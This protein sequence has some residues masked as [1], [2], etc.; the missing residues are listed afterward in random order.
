MNKNPIAAKFFIASIFC[1]GFFLIS[2]QRNQFL[3]P[4]SCPSTAPNEKVIQHTAYSL[5]YSH[6]HMQSKWVAYELSRFN[7][8]GSAERSRKF[9]ID[10]SI[11]PPTAQTSDYTK[12][13]YDRGHLAPAGDMKFSA[14]AML[15][16][17]YMSNVS[18]QLPGFNRGIWKKL[19]EQCRSWAPTSHPIFMVTGP[20]L[21][22][23]LN[24]H[25]GKTCS[26]SVPKR[27][28]KVLLDTAAP[29]RAIGF[30][31]E[32]V[33]STLPLRNFALSIDEVEKITG[34]DFFPRLN[35]SQESKL[36]KQVS[37]QGWIFH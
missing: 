25:I 2:A 18:P 30:V 12:T 31:L 1:L 11:S 26:I 28:F 32:N 22:D 29:M 35:D 33:S 3:Y 10:P 20:I 16:S 13:G 9:S 4:W 14:S 17:F 23:N 27:F 15:E 7:I 6:K 19:E 36:E 8:T 24:T 34:L 21:T 37:I 5:V